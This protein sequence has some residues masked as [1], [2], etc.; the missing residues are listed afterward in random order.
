MGPQPSDT[1]Q[2]E[3]NTNQTHD[4]APSFQPPQTLS[5]SVPTHP[6]APQT[7]PPYTPP[8]ATAQQPFQVPPAG[9]LP[10]TGQPLPPTNAPVAADTGQTF[11][12][13]GL[14]L[15]F[16]LLSLVGLVFSIISTVKAS[17]AGASK[18]LGIVGIILNS[19]AILATG[20][21]IL[22]FI[23]IGAAASMQA[24]SQVTFA[25]SEERSVTAKAEVY[26]DLYHAYPATISDFEKNSETKI[27]PTV[28]VITSDPTDAYSVKY[29]QCSPTGA[30]VVYYDSSTRELVVTPLGDAPIY[31]DCMTTSRSALYN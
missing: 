9:P 24:G 22:L 25:Q 29:Q 17:K 5:D 16:V 15:P 23:I 20:G 3:Q 6:Q 12:I 8:L 11:G 13:I 14:I 19:F 10:T 7:P 18:T 27:D 4:D 26:Y 31:N 30:Q 21:T 2:S 1:N 28:K